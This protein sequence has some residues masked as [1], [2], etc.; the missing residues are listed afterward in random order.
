MMLKNYCVTF[1]RVKHT[2]LGAFII[3]L[4]EI[5]FI[6]HP[7]EGFIFKGMVVKIS[8]AAN[9]GQIADIAAESRSTISIF[10]ED[11]F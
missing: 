10:K 7:C 5:F 2:S 4:R 8:Q 9:L 6:K 11:F 3:V 1:Y